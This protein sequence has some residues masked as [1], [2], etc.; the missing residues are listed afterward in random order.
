MVGQGRGE[1]RGCRTFS[2]ESWCQGHHWV[3]RNRNYTIKFGPGTEGS[4]R[5]LL[6]PYVWALGVHKDPPVEQRLGSGL[7]TVGH[8]TCLPP[9]PPTGTT[10]SVC[11]QTLTLGL[12]G[13]RHPNQSQRARPLGR[14]CRRL[15]WLTAHLAR[16]GP[17]AFSALG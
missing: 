16:P 17:S 14:L 1:W 7:L 9:T 6:E 4:L 10:L 12:P 5:P 15:P 8:P 2:L 13:S 11:F 3:P